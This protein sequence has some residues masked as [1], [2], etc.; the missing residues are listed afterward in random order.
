MNPRETD[1]IIAGGGPVGLY[2]AGRLLQ[3]GVRCTVLEKKKE[4]DRHS[5]SL[6][7]HPASLDLFDRAGITN[8]F[9]DHGLK[10]RKG[11]AFWNRAKIGEITFEKCPPPH[12]YILA[13]PQWQT[14]QILENWVTSL[15]PDT[16][17]RGAGVKSFQ[18]HEESVEVLCS[19]DEGS[20]SITGK[21]LVGCDGKNSI[22]RQIADI[23]LS[24]GRYPDCYMMG[25]YEDNTLFGND[26]AVYLHPEGLVE[27]F[28]LPNGYRRWVAK[29]DRYLSD[30]DPEL[31]SEMILTRLGHSLKECR[32]VMISS[33]GVQHQLAQT[34]CS[35]RILLAGDA[36]HV[37]S[38]IG[39]QGMNLGWIGAEH[40]ARA[41]TA[42]FERNG[43]AESPFEEYSRIQR[44]RSRQVA[45]RAEMNMH[46]GRSETSDLFYKCLVYSLIRSPLSHLLAKLF[47]MRGIGRWPL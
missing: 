15:N 45:R 35:G 8:E 43:Q 36:A 14:E 40:C 26:A 13:L 34:L 10:I 42:S 29:T 44:K 38:P 28:P 11:I 32:N 47:T 16:I 39:G 31:L 21:W 6:G 19:H 4:I 25:D 20:F 23:P 24:G 41:I 12:R 27:S 9:I 5:K 7:I 22:I 18:E 2:L 37:V 30:P 1:I 33:F 46:L 3:Q 17:I